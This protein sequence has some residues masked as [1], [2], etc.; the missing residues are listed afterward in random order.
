MPELAEVESFRSHIE[1]LLGGKKVLTAE[2]FADDIV[3]KSRKKAVPLVKALKGKKLSATRRYG[4]HMSVV[5]QDTTILLHFGMSGSL[6]VRSPQGDYSLHLK[7]GTKLLDRKKFYKLRVEFTDHSEMVFEDPRRFGRIEIVVGE[8]D[9]RAK[10]SL[11]YDLLTN[12]PPLAE[13]KKIFAKSARPIKGF[14][15]D[16]TLFAGVGNWLADEIL[17]DAKIAPDRLARTLSALEVRSLRL[18]SIKIVKRA[19]KVNADDERFPLHWLFHV[20][21]NDANSFS[22]HGHDLRR[23]QVAGRTTVWVPALQR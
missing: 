20:R 15:L 3:I 19:V 1:K 2:L 22:P 11:G 16:Q 17:F 12:P 18:S 10:N 14:L 6:H 13:L 8:V 21:W 23:A 4:K 7:N 5:F 9:L